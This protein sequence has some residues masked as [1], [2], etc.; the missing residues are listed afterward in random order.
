MYLNYYHLSQKPFQINTD[1]AFLW[2][3]EKHQEALATF[4]YGLYEN[5]GFLLLTGDVG[6]GKTTVINAMLR[7]LG[8]SDL[9]VSVH[10]PSFEPLDFFNFLARSF[11]LPDSY[12]SKGAFVSDFKDF[13]LQRHYRGGRVLLIIDESQL[14]SHGLLEEIRLLSNLEK[15]G[16][17]LINIFFVGQT[18]F[19]DILLRPENRAI[20]QRITVNYNIPP[21]TE[22]E[23]RD[24]I[25]YRLAVAGVYKKLFDKGALREIYRFSNGYPRLINIIADRALLTGYTRNAKKIDRSI[26]RECAQE[27][28]I[29]NNLLSASQHLP[30]GGNPG[31]PNTPTKTSFRLIY[32]LFPP[33]VILL[34][35]L[36]SYFSDTLLPLLPLP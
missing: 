18:E 25:E 24:Y 20:R 21:L 5:K 29:S 23:T 22:Q 32:L 14:L 31:T 6:V 15:D 33:L 12:A 8:D 34:V 36:M 13:L 2:L 10:D 7:L 9:A 17:K 28:D 26:V 4:K 19:N 3:G 35:L 27:L 30:H 1:P 11:G 16:M